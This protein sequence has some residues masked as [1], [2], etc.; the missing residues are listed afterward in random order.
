VTLHPKGWAV[1][2]AETAVAMPR[3]MVSRAGYLLERF[4]LERC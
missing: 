4:F 2:L 1:A 3:M